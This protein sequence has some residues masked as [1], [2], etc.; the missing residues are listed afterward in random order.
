M[1]SNNDQ[2]VQR[3]QPAPDHLLKEN[4][5]LLKAV[6]AAAGFVPNGFYAVGWKPQI[7]KAMIQ[8]AL[9]VLNDPGKIGKEL[10]W[11]VANMA[12]RS[13]GCRYCWAHTGSNAHN[14]GGA[15][16]EKVAAIWEFRTNDLFNDKERAAL[17]FAIAAAAVPNGVNNDNFA[18]IRKYFDDE[19]IV[20]IMSVISLFGWYNRWNDSMAT[21]LEEEPLSFAQKSLTVGGWD[22]GKTTGNRT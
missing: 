16:L 18:A 2:L 10:K 7:L 20:E 14:L 21:M 9:A 15:S 6:E 17:E 4:A 12:S 22:E 19:E 1:I 8:L 5:E 3:V 13:V 11:L